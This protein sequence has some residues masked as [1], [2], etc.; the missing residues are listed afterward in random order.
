[1]DFSENNLKDE[2]ILA[3][4]L[5]KP[6]LFRILVDRYQEAFVRKALGVLR[7]REEAEDIVQETFVKIYFN[8]KKFKKME[9]IEFKS[10]A[11][12]IL[13]NTAISRYR[14]ISKKWQMEST[15]PI[16]LELAS[17]R[18]LSTEDLVLQGEKKSMTADL[19]SRLPKPLARLVSLYYIEDK[20]YKE[21]AK[22]E[23]LTIPALKMKLFRAKKFL[24]N[25]VNKD[26]YKK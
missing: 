26:E 10:W 15:D 24:R 1:M 25:L 4:S 21:I 6:A 8:G 13:V 20:S 22:Q 2:E 7:Q 23:S 11:Y 14:K 17:E 9:G 5:E 3:A 19:I 12:K 18:N 16:E